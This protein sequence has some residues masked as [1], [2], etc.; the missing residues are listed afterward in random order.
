MEAKAKG[1]SVNTSEWDEAMQPEMSGRLYACYLKI[2][3]AA[4]KAD[5]INLAISPSGDEIRLEIPGMPGN[6][7][8]LATIKHY[9]GLGVPDSMLDSIAQEAAQSLSATA[10]RKYIK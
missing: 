10:L 6:I 9:Q 7:L 4:M 1:K 2:D 8:D 3:L 5:G